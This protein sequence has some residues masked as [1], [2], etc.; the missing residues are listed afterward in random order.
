[1]AS[2]IFSKHRAKAGLAVFFNTTTV[3]L[4]LENP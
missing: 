4:I 2:S 1:M 3:H